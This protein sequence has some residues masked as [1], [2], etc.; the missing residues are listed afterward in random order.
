MLCT[1]LYQEACKK[2][3]HDFPKNL[4]KSVGRFVFQNYICAALSCPHRF[5]LLKGSFIFYCKMV[6]SAHILHA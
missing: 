1:Q 6:P 2:F 5:T 4:F 3:P